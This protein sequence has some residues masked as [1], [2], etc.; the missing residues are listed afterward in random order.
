MHYKL[1]ILYLCCFAAGNPIQIFAQ[2]R[3]YTATPEKYNIKFSEKRI[4]TPDGAILNLWIYPTDT[5]VSN[6]KTVIILV[7]ADAG[8]MGDLITYAHPLCQQG[9]DIVCFDYRGF[10]ASSDFICL[11]NALYCNEFVTDVKSVIEYTR[12]AYPQY[13]IGAFAF[14]MGTI[15]ATL[16]LETHPLDFFITDCL[17]ANIPKFTKC[18]KKIS[19]GKQLTYPLSALG[20]EAVLKDMTI[21]ILMFVGL[22]DNR[23]LLDDGVKTLRKGKNRTLIV[24]QG[25]HLE[26]ISVLEMAYF[27][28]IND[29]LKNSK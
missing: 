17:V 11:P 24:Y 12:K 6:R 25:G 4:Q 26:G 23:K 22:N 3:D 28:Y 19:K 20:T 13:R 14:S 29:F 18:F 5:I 15:A 16:A 10:G 9:Y 7:N 8:N 27:N 2:S 21:P 1:F